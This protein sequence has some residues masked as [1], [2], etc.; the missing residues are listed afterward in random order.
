MRIGNFGLFRDKYTWRVLG[1]SREGRI[2]GSESAAR[3]ALGA[4]LM[5][6][7][8]EVEAKTADRKSAHRRAQASSE[9]KWDDFLASMEQEIDVARACTRRA[10]M[11]AAEVEHP[12]GVTRLL[13]TG[14][15]AEAVAPVAPENTAC[16]V[17]Y[18][19]G[20][21]SRLYARAVDWLPHWVDQNQRAL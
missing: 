19:R 10:S 16:H 17:N 21:S 9:R 7:P 6:A 4:A 5:D 8:T 1:G 3:D 20:F 18:W 13:K 12:S 11:L 14:R 2:G 15:T